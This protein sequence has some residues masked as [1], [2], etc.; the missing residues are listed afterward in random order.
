M[1]HAIFTKKFLYI[2][3]SLSSQ[4]KLY[5]PLLK[6]QKTKS[7]VLESKHQPTAD[8]P[9]TSRAASSKANGKPSR[10]LKLKRKSVAHASGDG[11]TP[12][13]WNNSKS[14]P[15]PG[16]DRFCEVTGMY[17]TKYTNHS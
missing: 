14:T 2:L 11:N 13:R 1:K 9:P 4:F 10:S 7:P 3:V 8:T 16:P 12:N 6:G 15:S 5:R 17:M